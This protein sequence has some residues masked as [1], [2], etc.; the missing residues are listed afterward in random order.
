MR[1]VTVMSLSSHWLVISSSS[2]S[3]MECAAIRYVKV[4]FSEKAVLQKPGGH[5]SLAT[6]S[7]TGKT[8]RHCFEKKKSRKC[9]LIQRNKGPCRRCIRI[10]TSRGGFYRGAGS[11]SEFDYKFRAESPR[12]KRTQLEHL[13]L[14]TLNATK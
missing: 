7:K 4:C 2:E 9:S 8:R 1:N 11:H 10:V 14:R 13:N 3:L 5:V 12:I 6:F